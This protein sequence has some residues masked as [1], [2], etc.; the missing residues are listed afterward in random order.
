MQYLRSE[1][2]CLVDSVKIV[3]DRGSGQSKHF[4]FAQFASLEGAEEFV[5]NKYVFDPASEAFLT[6]SASRQ[7]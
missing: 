3:R 1:H 4:G 6:T 5:N 2:R 7:S